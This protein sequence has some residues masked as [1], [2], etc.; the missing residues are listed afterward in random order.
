MNLRL[1]GL[2]LFLP[3]PV[4]L[5]LYTRMPLG[6][7]PSL[8]AGTLIMLTHA[9]YARPFALR[10]AGRRCLWCGVE[11]TGEEKPAERSGGE[12]ASPSGLDAAA[13]GPAPLRILEPRGLTVWRTCTQHHR[14]RLER[15][16]GYAS[17]HAAGLRMGI[18]GTLVVFL[19]GAVLIALGRLPGPDM[20]D[21]VAFFQLGVALSVL[22][23]GWFGPHASRQTAA[24][25]Q[26]DTPTPIRIPFP[27]HLQALIGT[28]S[29]LWL[30]RL[31]GLLWLVRGVSHFARRF[32]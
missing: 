32:A 13:P 21:A 22:P 3:V 9:L 17:R 28:L 16:L 30:F 31:I 10:S 12:A 19:I 15:T 6:E 5:Y 1:A 20:D 14:Q 7:L 23:L 4:V 27:A 24:L 18:G 26:E 11:L 25:P 2:L 29:V 8:L